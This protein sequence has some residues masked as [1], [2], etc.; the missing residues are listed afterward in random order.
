MLCTM[1]LNDLLRTTRSLS[2][3]AGKDFDVVAVSFDPRDKPDLASRKKKTYLAQYNRPGAE[4]G[5]HFL[6]G[7]RA[8]INALTDA[9]GFRYTWDAKNQVFAHASG[10]MV[11]TPAGVLSRYFY[12][13][14]YAP[15]DL[16]LALIEAGENKTG[17]FTN[18]VLLYCFAYDPSTGKYSLLVS[19][20]LK[21]AGVATIFLLA[22]FITLSLL[23]DRR[24]LV[25]SRLRTGTA[26]ED[27]T[28]HE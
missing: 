18:A 24:T 11:S 26:P 23:R 17:S 14:D 21:V 6:T 10:I 4:D 19:R 13:I 2:E 1:V 27:E 20:I 22:S 9:V 5:W 16:R 8:S 25:G 28:P 3:T 12:G 15:T 7:D